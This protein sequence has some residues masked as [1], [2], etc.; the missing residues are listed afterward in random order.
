MRVFVFP[1][2]GSQAV[3]MGRDLFEQRPAS[4]RVFEEADDALGFALSRLCH[5]GPEE[6]LQL[7]AAAQ[8]AILTASVA[9]LIAL[10]EEGPGPDA[11]AGHSLG[12]YT[13]LV[14]AGALTFRDAVVLVHRRGLYMQEA[15]PVGEGTMAAIIGLPAAAVEDACR[16]AATA[17]SRV[18]A[19]ANLNAPDQTVISGH[20]DAVERAAELCRHRGARRAVRLPVSGPFHCALMAP[21]ARRL[22]VDLES[23]TFRDPSVPVVANV[24]ARPVP[25]GEEARRALADQV[26]ACVRWVESVR[27]LSD[28]GV[29]QAVEVGPGRVLSGL[30]KRI[31]PG[32]ACSS[33]GD[34]GAVRSA[35]ASI[36]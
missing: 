31:A 9:A 27:A 20:A 19:P 32:I 29:T 36:S 5:E 35:A 18:V 7:T 6:A 24:S 34:A 15:V 3:G 4:R 11:V 14:A 33:A 8:P 25:T 2:Q 13:A 30:I 12:E 28:M 22:V 10:R 26:T 23:V 21:A 17:T 16:E 1:G